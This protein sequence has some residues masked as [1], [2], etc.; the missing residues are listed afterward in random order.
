MNAAL[1]SARARRSATSKGATSRAEDAMDDA[2]GRARPPRGHLL[3]MLKSWKRTSHREAT[4]ALAR[5]G[6]ADAAMQKGSRRDARCGKIRMVETQSAGSSAE[7]TNLKHRARDLLLD[8][9]LTHQHASLLERRN[10]ATARNRS[11][12]KIAED[13]KTRTDSG[14]RV[15]AQAK[16]NNLSRALPLDSQVMRG[17]LPEREPRVRAARRSG[18]PKIVD[19]IGKRGQN[20]IGRAGRGAARTSLSLLKPLRQHPEARM[21][22]PRSEVSESAESQGQPRGLARAAGTQSSVT[23][24]E[25]R[26]KPQ[27]NLPQTSSSV[28]KAGKTSA[29]SQRV[30]RPQSAANPTFNSSGSAVTKELKVRNPAA[31]EA[32]NNSNHRAVVAK[33]EIRVTRREKVRAVPKVAR[34]RMG[35]INR[36]SPP[37]YNCPS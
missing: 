23:C 17:S 36:L 18:L 35:E 4:S 7:R 20:R 9:R 19:R 37:A 3:R 5:N 29:R 14:G 1:E 6:D 33:R 28:A 22:S 8:N 21:P 31:S 16:L 11:R 34:A 2:T 32:N 13:R 25:R 12:H 24:S 15:A 10:A 27:K 26:S 30:V